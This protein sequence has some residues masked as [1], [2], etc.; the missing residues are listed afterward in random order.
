MTKHTRTACGI[1]LITVLTIE[2]GGY[3]LLK[4]LSG[5]F[6][7]LVLTEFQKSMFRAGHAHA[8]V[9]VILSLIAII[10]SDHARLAGFWKW[11]VLFGFP[12]SAVLVSGGFFAA[13]IGTGATQPNHLIFILFLGVFV[14]TAALLTLGIGLIKK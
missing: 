3:F 5:S 2:Y 7:D 13:A 12:S 11:M 9:L 1:V 14:L 10:L 8:G 6:S 4:I